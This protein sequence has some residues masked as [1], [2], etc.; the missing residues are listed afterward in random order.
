MKR[1]DELESEQ[2]APAVEEEISPSLTFFECFFFC[3]C[4]GEDNESIVRR[5]WRLKLDDKFIDDVLV[6]VTRFVSLTDGN[7]VELF[8]LIEGIN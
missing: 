2:A 1:I 3:A 4:D 8:E 6:L 5:A 7:E